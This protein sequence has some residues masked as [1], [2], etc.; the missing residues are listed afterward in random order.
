MIFWIFV[1]FIM[2]LDMELPATSV[3]RKLSTI[4]YCSHMAI[5]MVV[6]KAFSIF[7][8]EDAQNILV[9]SITLMCAVV[10][11]FIIIK[12]ERYDRLRFLKYAH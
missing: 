2:N 3:M 6:S 9:F 8:V 4:V 1:L 7:H 10:L 12:L 5:M 11:S